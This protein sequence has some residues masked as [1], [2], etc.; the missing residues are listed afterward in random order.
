M[1]VQQK[2]RAMIQLIRPEL[3]AAAGI[4]VVIGQVYGKMT[5]LRISSLLFGGMIILTLFPVIWG[6][7]GLAY[8]IPITIMDGLI[9]FFTYKLVRSPTPQEGHNSMR[10]LYLSASF[11]LIVCIFGMFIW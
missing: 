2:S 7:A 5:A 11:G 6:E 4:C 8:V 1:T 10:G 9:I 3:P